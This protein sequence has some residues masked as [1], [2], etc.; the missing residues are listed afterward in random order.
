MK[1]Q[2]PDLSTYRASEVLQKRSALHGG[3]MPGVSKDDFILCK[4]F[5]HPKILLCT[6]IQK[7]IHREHQGTITEGTEQTLESGKHGGLPTGAKIILRTGSG[8]I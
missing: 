8:C 6:R 4:G 1:C 5:V 7:P 3:Y 2:W